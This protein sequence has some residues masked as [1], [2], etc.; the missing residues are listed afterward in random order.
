MAVADMSPRHQDPVGA[1]LKGLEDEIGI[2]PSG[3]HH[4]DNP[5]VGR[6]LKTAH[7]CKIR[8]RIGAPVAG[9]GNDLWAKFLRHNTPRND[10]K[11]KGRAIQLS[12][13]NVQSKAASTMVSTSWSS[14]W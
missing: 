7:A 10:R 12:I 4:P 13:V 8:S 3:T 5:H 14:K 1:L 2:D 6:V 11:L 9:K